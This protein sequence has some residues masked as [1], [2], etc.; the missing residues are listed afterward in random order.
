MVARAC[1]ISSSSRK[2]TAMSRPGMLGS[3]PSCGCPQSGQTYVSWCTG[4]SAAAPSIT[5]AISA[6]STG[7]PAMASSTSSVR[8]SPQISSGN[9]NCSPTARSQASTTWSATLGSSCSAPAAAAVISA[10]LGAVLARLA[11]TRTR[12]AASAAAHARCKPGTSIALR[13]LPE[14]SGMPSAWQASTAI[15]G[16]STPLAVSSR[17]GPT[18]AASLTA[19]ANA[20]Q[21]SAASAISDAA[22]SGIVTFLASGRRWLARWGISQPS[23]SRDIG[24]CRGFVALGAPRARTPPPPP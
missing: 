15:A 16:R 14:A 13:S 20:S 17:L 19:P 11:A 21:R 9:P 4:S 1:S 3:D 23:Q 10:A 12:S 22:K 7:P 5:T 18:H 8:H 6:I 24:R 2:A